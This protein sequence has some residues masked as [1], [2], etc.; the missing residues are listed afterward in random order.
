M[1]YALL[2]GERTIRTVANAARRDAEEFMPLAA[3]IPI[4]TDIQTFDL[5]AANRVLQKLK[6]SAITG[7]AVLRIR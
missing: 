3:E 2:W 7:A 5:D 1:P 4:H 6:R